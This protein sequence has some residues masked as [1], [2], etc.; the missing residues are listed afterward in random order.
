MGFLDVVYLEE[1]L[2]SE[3][4]AK[5]AFFDSDRAFSA[6]NPKKLCFRL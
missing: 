1:P 2:L 5:T 3:R 4:A 6:K